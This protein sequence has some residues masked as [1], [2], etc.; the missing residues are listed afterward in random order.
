MQVPAQLTPAD[1]ATVAGAMAW[2]Y[3]QVTGRPPVSQSSWL[4]P[5]GQSAFET[6]NWMKLFGWNVGFISQPN[7]GSLYF[8]RGSNPVP[9]AVYPTL[10]Q[11][12][13][14]M[15]R[16]LQKHGALAGA[17]NNDLGAYSAGLQSGNYLGNAGDYATYAAGIAS[18]MQR[19]AGVVPTPYV[20]APPSALSPLKLTNPQAIALGVGVLAAAALAAYTLAPKKRAWQRTTRRRTA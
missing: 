19:Y 20:D 6:A 7:K 3:T 8:F 1:P 4:M 5:L 14:A 16:W 9:F 10:G 11:G 12:C 2:A 15:M 17:D 18:E 13:I